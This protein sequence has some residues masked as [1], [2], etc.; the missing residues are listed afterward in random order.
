LHTVCRR[1]VFL[2]ADDHQHRRSEHNSTVFNDWRWAASPHLNAFATD[3]RDRTEDRHSHY[4]ACDLKWRSML[5]AHALLLKFHS[6]RVFTI[7]PR[8]FFQHAV[9]TGKFFPAWQSIK[10]PDGKYQ[11]HGGQNVKQL[12]HNPAVC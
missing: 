11:G 9:G 3:S 4:R 12:S 2:S 10:Q 6:T 1:P 7:F 5:N 8:H